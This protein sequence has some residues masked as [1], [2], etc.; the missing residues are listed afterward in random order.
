MPFDGATF[1]IDPLTLSTPRERLE[2]L[3]GFLRGLPEARFYMPNYVSD[4]HRNPADDTS[5]LRQCGTAACI[6]GWAAFLFH[7]DAIKSRNDGMDAPTAH[8]VAGLDLGLSPQEA[9]YLFT[10]QGWMDATP[11]EAADVLDHLRL[12]GKVNWEVARKVEA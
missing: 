11:T 6:A 9:G 8:H 2:Y 12:S 4:A 10:P 1:E 5:A 3:A 7:P